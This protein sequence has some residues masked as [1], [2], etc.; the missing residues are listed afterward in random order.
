MELFSS[1]FLLIRTHN[2]AY[3][4]YYYS[5]YIYLQNALVHDDDEAGEVRRAETIATNARKSGLNTQG[6]SR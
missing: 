2:K 4:Y 3:H 6:R 1:L 5:K